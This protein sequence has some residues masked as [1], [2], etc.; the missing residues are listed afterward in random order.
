M[1]DEE[2]GAIGPKGPTML[3]PP[4]KCPECGKE[5]AYTAMVCKKCGNVFSADEVAFDQY[6][7]TCPKCGYS[8]IEEKKSTK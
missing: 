7:D 6:Q 1:Q 8:A 4:L 2:K 5:A 3:P